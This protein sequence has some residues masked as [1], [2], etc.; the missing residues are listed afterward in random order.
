[1]VVFHK[2]PVH[3]HCLVEKQIMILALK[4]SKDE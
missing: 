4:D 2:Y 3:N 1:M